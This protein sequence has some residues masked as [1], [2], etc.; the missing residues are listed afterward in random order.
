M[1]SAFFR[2][3]SADEAQISSECHF[4][5]QNDLILSPPHALN[6]NLRVSIVTLYL[7][8]LSITTIFGCVVSLC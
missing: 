1:S 3:L 6:R 2:M 7:F 5:F 4:V 8:A